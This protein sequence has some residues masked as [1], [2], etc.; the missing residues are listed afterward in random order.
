MPL[1]WTISPLEHI[2]VCVADG[3]VTFADIMTYY[4]ALEKAQ[5][6]AYQKILV[7]AAGKSRLSK[8]EMA[9]I[10]VRLSA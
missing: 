7:A 9:G 1:R 4:D 10:A 5:A 8:E 3:I 6:V 2:V